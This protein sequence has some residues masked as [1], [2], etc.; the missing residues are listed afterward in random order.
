MRRAVLITVL[1]AA[2]AAFA[3]AL[4]ERLAERRQAA[5]AVEEQRPPAPVEIASIRVGAMTARRTFSGTLEAAAEFVVAPNVPGT[6]V[7]VKVDL[8]DVVERGQIVAWLDDREFVQDVNQAQ[9]ELAVARASEAEA[10]SALEL[11]ERAL[12]RAEALLEQGV[13]SE[14]QIDTASA[15][16]IASRATVEVTRANVVR[17]E[18][19]LEAARIRLDY[20]RVTADWPETVVRAATAAPDNGDGSSESV[21]PGDAAEALPAVPRDD[22][23]WVS[24]RWV[25]EGETVS[26]NTPLLSIVALDPIIAVVSVPERDYARIAL[27][28]RASLTTDAYPRRTFEGRVARIAPVFTRSTRQ[29][30]VELAVSNAE[31][32]LKPGMFVRATIELEQVED[33]I[34]VPVNALVERDAGT[35]IFVVDVASQRVAWR[36]VGLGVREAAHVEVFGEGLVGHVVTL[37]QELCEDGGQVR[38]VATNGRSSEGGAPGADALREPEPLRQPD[39]PRESESEPEPGPKAPEDSGAATGTAAG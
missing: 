23:R 25:D 15:E 26:A 38:V 30:R 5:S 8:G 22:R 3:W 21:R 9:A 35:G 27:D 28:Q 11:A 2:A 13:T 34:S 31:R 10:K 6:V 7:E 16:Q 24:E 29:A 4:T 1:L 18:A 17:A 39:V 36:P 20:A 12:R 14:S 33:A 19:A 37:G 32:A